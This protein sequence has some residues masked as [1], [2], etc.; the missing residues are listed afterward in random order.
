MT[1][2]ILFISCQCGVGVGKMK[3]SRLLVKTCYYLWVQFLFLEY[4]CRSFFGLATAKK[5]MRTVQKWFFV[6][7]FRFCILFAPGEWRNDLFLL[8]SRSSGLLLSPSLFGVCLFCSSIANKKLLFCRISLFSKRACVVCK[9]AGPAGALILFWFWLL[10][11]EST[12]ELQII[13]NICQKHFTSLQVILN[14]RVFFELS[15]LPALRRGSWKED[16][17][18]HSTFQRVFL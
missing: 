8:V 5:L 4:C 14:L 15:K 18:L 10:F 3:V 12:D 1:K 2:E 7:T 6:V 13:V 9:V 11:L 16:T 17:K